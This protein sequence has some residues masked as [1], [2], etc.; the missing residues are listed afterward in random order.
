VLV[1]DADSAWPTS[2]VLNLHPKLTLHDVFTGQT[3]LEDAILPAPGLLGAAGR[4][5]NDRVFG[6]TP[7]VRDQLAGGDRAWCVRASIACCSTPAPAS[8]CRALH[9]VSGDEVLIVA[10]PS[11]HR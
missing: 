8:R 4:I 9:S 1:L 5:G 10:T 7:T 3:K 11:R 2:C 6:L